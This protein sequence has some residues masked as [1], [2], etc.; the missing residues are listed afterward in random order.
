[1]SPRQL[2]QPFGDEPC[3]E[4]PLPAAPLARVLAQLRFEPLSALNSPTISSRF[5]EELSEKYPYLDKAAEI[6][7]LIEGGKI[8]PQTSTTPVWRLSSADRTVTISLSN[9][10]LSIETTEYHGRSDFCDELLQA[11]DVLKRLARVPAYVRVGF[12]YTNRIINPD[13]IAHLPDLV[14]P[15]ILGIS[16]V[17]LGPDA[18]LQH[19]LSQAAFNLSDGEGFLAQWGEMPPSSTF[20]PS[21]LPISDRSWI[22]DLDSFYQNPRINS[23]L[24]N[25]SETINRLSDRA[26]RFFR[27]AVTPKFLVEFGGSE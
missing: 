21:V 6:N 17:R 15:E 7:M 18:S 10:F 8:S 19:S 3:E 1:M 26:Y 24:A 14:R 22:L 20:D 27:W 11:A 5:A 9:G 4:V 13:I 23:D 2:E 16:S 25:L 12:R